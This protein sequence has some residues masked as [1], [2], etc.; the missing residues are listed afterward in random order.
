MGQTFDKTFKQEAV[1]LVQ[2]SG[3]SQRQ[4]AEDLGVAMST[5]SRW[6]TEMATNGEQAFVGSG[7]Q[8]PEA[9]ELRRLRRENEVLRQKRDI[10]KKA[11]A[12]FSR[13]E[14]DRFL[15][16]EHHREHF[17]VRIMC[18]VLGVSTGGFYAVAKASEK[19]QG[20]GRWRV[21]REALSMLRHFTIVCGNTQPWAISVQ[22]SL[23]SFIV[24]LSL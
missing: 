5:L 14:I 18:R 1:R 24:D 10:L 9:E 19:L 2:T 13:P 7:N 15:F 17:E 8:Q 23:K 4:V 21:D 16:I 11:V 3:K 6:C 22:S 20:A 12:I